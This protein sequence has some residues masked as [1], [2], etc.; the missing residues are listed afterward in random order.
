MSLPTNSEQLISHLPCGGQGDSELPTAM[1]QS[2]QQSQVKSA[3]VNQYQNY[4]ERDEVRRDFVSAVAQVLDLAVV[5]TLIAALEDTCADI[6]RIAAR[7]LTRHGNHGLTALLAAIAF[8]Q[9]SN[10]FY[11]SA[12]HA[13]YILQFHA[14]LHD[15]QLITMLLSAVVGPAPAAVA[16][17][18][19]T[20]AIQA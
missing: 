1:L 3:L 17:A 19:A 4:R 13:L 5:P 7:G 15:R 11:R 18:I 16:P 10:G 6:R 8:E 14:P 20:Q 9:H 12:H 2:L